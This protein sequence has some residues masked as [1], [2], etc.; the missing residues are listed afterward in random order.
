MLSG[1]ATVPMMVRLLV[2][3]LGFFKGPGSDVSST[4]CRRRELMA[5]VRKPRE[6]LCA[7]EFHP[8][9]LDKKGTKSARLRRPLCVRVF[10]VW[11]GWNSLA[12]NYSTGFAK[13]SLI[14]SEDNMTSCFELVLGSLE[15]FFVLFEQG[16]VSFLRCP[17]EDHK[18]L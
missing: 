11:E 16:E 2:L 3:L 12:H 15:L 7:S 10:R 1:T 9:K 17:V 5:G 13:C 6:K 14:V 4:Y 18:T 8:P